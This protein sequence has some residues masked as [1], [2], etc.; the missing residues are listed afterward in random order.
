[1][2]CGVCAV[3]HGNAEAGRVGVV[4]GLALVDVVIGV[5]D[6]VTALL[7]THD[8]EGDVGQYFVG[9]HVDGG[10]C[11]TLVN[12]D[13]E[14]VETFAGVQHQVA[15]F[16]DLVSNF[17]TDG[18]QFA[19]RQGGGLLGQHHAADKFRNVRNLL[20]AQ[21]EVFDCALGMHAV[22]ELI[23]NFFGAQQVFFNADVLDVA[24][25]NASEIR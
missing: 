20:S 3:Y 13:R 25:C 9:V 2:Q 1:M 15:G 7:Q 17:R 11:T 24:H 19:V 16:Y 21:L 14:L 18:A 5:D 12:V 4:G 10:A 23:G 22:V 8:L 6:V